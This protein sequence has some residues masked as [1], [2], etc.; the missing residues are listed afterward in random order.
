MQFSSKSTTFKKLRRKTFGAILMLSI[1]ASTLTSLALASAS[2]IFA[3]GFESGNFAAWSGT[4]G[5]PQIVTNPTYDGKYAM[6]CDSSGEVAYKT[7]S[8]YNTAYTEFYVNLNIQPDNGKSIKIAKATDSALHAIWE[9]YFTESTA[10]TSQIQLKSSAPSTKNDI[11][12]YPFVANTWYCVEVEYS[13]SA[14]GGYRVWI[15][16]I[17]VLSRTGVDTSSVELGRLEFGNQWSNYA[18]TVNIDSVVISASYVPPVAIT[19]PTQNHLITSVTGSGTTNPAVGSHSYNEGAV[20]SVSSTPASGWKL[21][22]WELD[23]VNVGSANPIS[24]TMDSDHSLTGVFLQTQV[25]YLFADGF[26]SGNFAAWSGTIG[27]PQI[28]TNPTYDGKY[29]MECD[30]SGEVAYKTLSG[31]NTAYTEFYTQLS[32]LPSD[33]QSVKVAKATDSGLQA[34]WELYFTRSSSGTLQV[35]LKS[36]VPSMSDQSADYSYSANTWY[37]IEVQYLQS[38]SG[39][40]KVWINGVELTSLS[41]TSDTSGTGLSRLELGNQWSN[42]AVSATV[43]TVAIDQNYIGTGTT[44]PVEPI[45][46]TNPSNPTGTAENSAMT[47]GVDMWSGTSTSRMSSYLSEMQDAGITTI[48]LEFNSGSIANLRTLV[49][50]A[51]KNGIKIIG[52]LLRTDLAPDNVDAWGNWVYNTVNEFKS[53]VHV[54]EM[55]NEPNLDKFFPGKDPVKYTNFL[56]RGYTEAKLADPTCFVLGGSIAFTHSYAQNFLKIMYHNGA[57]NYMDA[58]SWHPYCTPYAPDDLS[59]PNPFIKLADIRNIMVQNGAADKKIWITEVGWTSNDD[60]QVGEQNQ[61]NYLVQ[62]LNIAKNWGWVDTFI[63]YNWKDSSSSGTGTKGLLHTDYS[64]K[65]A[66]YAVK[67]FIIG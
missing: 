50:Y 25:S 40:Y 9:L 36:S 22:H 35:R 21:D 24:V 11:A 28:V 56:K 34:I 10:G 66:Y 58:L 1:I 38:T 23:G 29:A 64:P 55:W 67:D 42:Y 30:S 43:D 39:G 49:P 52:L 14:S 18:A 53:Y 54:W 2:P 16:G 26:E 63:I 47:V 20:A 61:A 48:R 33:G 27:S 51:T 31:Y 59:S 45:N 5:S 8:G 4:I 13:Q 37:C 62:A 44:N 57:N 60:G 7:L 15:N 3:D 6:E 65:P 41:R 32:A 17:E 12:T 19:T 46:T